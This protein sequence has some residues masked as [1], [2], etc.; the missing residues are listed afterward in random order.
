MV[1]LGDRGTTNINPLWEPEQPFTEEQYRTRIRWIW[2][3]TPEQI[4][5]TRSTKEKIIEEANQL[6]KEFDC[7]IKIFGTE[8]WK[9]I[10]RLAIAIAGYCVSTDDTYENIVVHTTHVSA[11]VNFLR[12]IYDNSVF[13][14]REYVAHERQFSTTD[15]A[16]TVL[17]QD[18]WNKTPGIV[19]QLEQYASVT[20]NMLSATTGLGNEELNKT[21]NRL[22]KGLFIQ[23][24][25]FEIIPT[26]RF[27]LT[28]STIERNTHINPIGER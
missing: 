9:K 13:K 17:L 10:S 16:A 20:K 11:A 5:L 14:L 26:E 18:I 4:I 21:L 2:S 27:R 6:N 7:H 15:E 1:V 12:S 22:T 3:R 25:N 28:L 19:Q 8:A 24:S 23:V